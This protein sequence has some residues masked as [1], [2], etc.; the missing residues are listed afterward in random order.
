MCHVRSNPPAHVCVSFRSAFQATFRC[1]IPQTPGLVKVCCLLF[2]LSPYRPLCL[3]SSRSS[4]VVPSIPQHRQLV[5]V[6]TSQ[7]GR[8]S[9]PN[10]AQFQLVLLSAATMGAGVSLGEAQQILTQ[11]A[12]SAIPHIAQ[13]LSPATSQSHI[14]PLIS[15]TAA[16]ST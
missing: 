11:H 10:A 3:L 15:P 12:H 16:S 8:A 4:D 7:G 13:Q 14:A 6:L 2:A 9:A 5:D 1:P